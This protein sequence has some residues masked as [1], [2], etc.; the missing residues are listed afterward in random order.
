MKYIHFVMVCVCLL[1]LCVSPVSGVETETII[2]YSEP[3]VSVQD[4]ITLEQGYSFK[5][6]DMNSKS[7]DVMIELYL[8]GEEIDLDNNFAAEDNP[9]E[10]VRSVA[11]DDDEEVD[12]FIM[13]ITPKGSVKESD[14][15]YYSI[16][17][18]EQYL[19]P[20]EDIDEY[21]ILGESYSFKSDSDF[22]L[23]NSY[24]LDVA[25]IEDNELSL[26][27]R[28]NGKLLKEDDVEEGEYFYYTVYSGN[29]PDTIF[30][31]N[32]KAFIE[33]DDSTTVFLKQVSL[34]QNSKSVP[35]KDAAAVPEE[36]DID[37]ESPVGGDLKAGSIAI[38]TYGVDEAF[39]EV[40]ILVDGEFVDSRNDVSKGTYKAVTGE[41]D[42]GIHDVMLIMID[43]EDFSYYSEDFSVSVNIKDNITE[44]I[45]G[46]ASSAAE[47]IVRDNS[48]SNVS[49]NSSMPSTSG[50]SISNVISLI[51]TVG[52][53]V[54]FF[55]FYNKFR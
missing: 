11:D 4:N 37:V 52:V 36:I 9:L 1:V 44:S 50:S 41:M 12:Y 2:H 33:S 3:A 8:N 48:S 18:I 38:I 45:A 7:G 21:L 26:E 35:D 24:T 30:L 19:D 6:V 34:K 25:G 31:A 32:V 5:V 46:I 14:G 15:K 42:A 13:R 27:L 43:G 23:A 54:V 16:I 29:Q 40:R 47:S 17:Y 22:K 28:L 49:F 51:V 20:V 39:T 55:V 10:Y 53:F